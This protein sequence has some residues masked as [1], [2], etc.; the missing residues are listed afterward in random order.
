MDTGQLRS[1]ALQRFTSLAM[2]VDREIVNLREGLRRGYAAP[3]RNVEQ[4]I[5]QMKGFGAD[6]SPYFSPPMRA[7]SDD[8]TAAWRAMVRS[9]R[10]GLPPV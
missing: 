10:A 5:G 6:D 3:R 9:A 4:V 7:R 2:N 1:D 8:F